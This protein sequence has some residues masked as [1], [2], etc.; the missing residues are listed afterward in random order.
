MSCFDL[1]KS[2]L[3]VMQAVAIAQQSFSTNLFLFL[4]TTEEWTLRCQKP[5][6]LYITKAKRRFKKLLL[7]SICYRQQS[8]GYTWLCWRLFQKNCWNEVCIIPNAFQLF[9]IFASFTLLSQK[10]KTNYLKFAVFSSLLKQIVAFEYRSCLQS[11]L[12]FR[13]SMKKTI[14]ENKNNT[15]LSKGVHS[16]INNIQNRDHTL[17]EDVYHD[18]WHTVIIISNFQ[19]KWMTEFSFFLYE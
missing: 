5:I 18:V 3:Y 10:R 4:F 2:W 19:W 6:D 17:T 15:G 9:L 16:G 7:R 1:V 11:L 8:F 14:N 12:I 13:Q